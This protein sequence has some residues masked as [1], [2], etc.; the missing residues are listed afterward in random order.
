MHLI[1]WKC[2]NFLNSDITPSNGCMTFKFQRESNR[3]CY[4][5]KK[6]QLPEDGLVSVPS[7]RNRNCKLS[8]KTMST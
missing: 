4:T 8:D 7:Y 1:K 3:V 2:D 5:K 6:K